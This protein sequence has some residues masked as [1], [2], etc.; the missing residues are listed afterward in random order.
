MLDKISRSLYI[1]TMPYEL[2]ENATAAES[3]EEYLIAYAEHMEDLY[4]E[5]QLQRLDAMRQGDFD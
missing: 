2:D 5:A 1:L 3:E 4:E